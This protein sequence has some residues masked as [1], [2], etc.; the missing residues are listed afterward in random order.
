MVKIIVYICLFLCVATT[1]ASQLSYSDSLRGILNKGTDDSTQIKLLYHLTQI[2]GETRPDSSVYFANELYQLA[3]KKGL[4]LV[5][6]EATAFL[7]YGM[8]N[9]GNYPVSLDFLFKGLEIATDP[10]SEKDNWRLNMMLTPRQSRLT[11]LAAIHLQLGY[12]YN[13]DE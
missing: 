1:A 11:V 7:G 8:V 13:A 3:E 4:R 2:Y 10:K 9:L 5:Q 6:A 12:T